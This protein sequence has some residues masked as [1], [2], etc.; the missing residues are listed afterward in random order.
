MKARFNVIDP[1]NVGNEL[2]DYDDDDYEHKPSYKCLYFVVVSKNDLTV[3]KCDRLY[4][5]V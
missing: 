3:T 2:Y 5:A 4:F 1:D